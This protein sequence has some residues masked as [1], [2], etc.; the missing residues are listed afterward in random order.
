MVC[1]KIPIFIGREK[2][3]KIIYKWHLFYFYLNTHV[4]GYYWE[5]IAANF[6]NQVVIQDHIG[7]LHTVCEQ[8]RYDPSM[9]ELDALGYTNRCQYPLRPRELVPTH[10][11]CQI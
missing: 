2:K 1:I 6:G 7:R 5:I 3:F 4:V 10:S 8:T 11:L 9:E